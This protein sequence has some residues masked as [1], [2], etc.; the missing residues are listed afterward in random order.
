MSGA[1]TSERL[2]TLHG[3]L[4][5]M[6]VRGE[7]AEALSLLIRQIGKL[8]LDDSEVVL[9]L[10]QSLYDIIEG[11]AHDILHSSVGG[12][13]KGTSAAG[14]STPAALFGSES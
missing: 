4:N 10:L 12:T 1:T 5:A 6:Q 2:V 7:A 3:R 11:R 13:P 9:E 8:G 14:A